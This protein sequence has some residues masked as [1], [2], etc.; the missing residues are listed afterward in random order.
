MTSWTR[1][2]VSGATSGRLFRTRE[3]VWIETPAAEATSRMVRRFFWATNLILPAHR[4]SFLDS[5]ADASSSIDCR[6]GGGVDQV[7]SP[8]DNDGG[9]DLALSRGF[10]SPTKQS[11]TASSEPVQELLHY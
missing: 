8:T 5:I 4:E 3:T 11:E 9:E 10:K 7:R 6:F 1:C 2:N